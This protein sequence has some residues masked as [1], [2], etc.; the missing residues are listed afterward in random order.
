MDY[1][2]TVTRFGQ[3]HVQYIY[4]YHILVIFIIPKLRH[5]T[6]LIPGCLPQQ[7]DHHDILCLHTNLVTSIHEPG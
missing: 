4:L 6:S 5:I 7:L 2:P 1:L 3:I